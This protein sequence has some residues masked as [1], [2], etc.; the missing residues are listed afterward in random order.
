MARFIVIDRGTDRV[1]GDTARFGSAG[2]V[3]SPAD[4]VCLFDRHVGR[5]TRGFG[6][7]KPNSDAA[8]HDVYEIP[9]SVPH[10]ATASEAEARAL[11][12]EHGSY[13]AAL[14]SYNS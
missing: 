3:V 14:V 11:V 9:Q 4:A 8:S 6:Y 10:R 5:A 7:V 12:K 13:V 2:D 1:Y